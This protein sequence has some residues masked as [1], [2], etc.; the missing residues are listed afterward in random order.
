MNPCPENE[1][2]DPLLVVGNEYN[3][4]KHLVFLPPLQNNG[5][6]WGLCCN[7]A[8]RR[9]TFAI[10]FSG[11]SFANGVALLALVILELFLGVF[12]NCNKSYI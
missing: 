5:K 12:P 7:G 1:F 3:K 8:S 11:A 9:T 2:P 10:C 6:F 4:R